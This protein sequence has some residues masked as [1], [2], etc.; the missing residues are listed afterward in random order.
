[1]RDVVSSYRAVY[2]H[3]LRHLGY[4]YPRR[5]LKRLQRAT[6]RC[7]G[8]N[9]FLPP[10]VA[11]PPYAPFL[12]IS[13]IVPGKAAGHGRGALAVQL[14]AA[15]RGGWG[16]RFGYGVPGGAL[17]DNCG[18]VS[19]NFLKNFFPELTDLASKGYYDVYLRISSPLYPLRRNKIPKKRPLAGP[20]GAE[21]G[22]GSGD[23]RQRRP[24]VVV[25]LGVARSTNFKIAETR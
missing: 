11:P 7:K 5:R 6:M 23:P 16:I 24:S 3:S 18:G 14:V 8:V 1:L 13:L 4:P 17:R 21:P 25:V 10:A 12:G 2:G 9:P 20:P 15:R 22:R 19:K